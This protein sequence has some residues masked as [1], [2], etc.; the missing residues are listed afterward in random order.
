MLVLTRKTNEDIVIG[1]DIQ[2]KIIRIQGNSVQLGVSAP[3][4]VPVYRR[5]VYERRAREV[6]A[7]SVTK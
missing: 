5:E 3:D 7:P 6:P 1:D 2:V 4:T